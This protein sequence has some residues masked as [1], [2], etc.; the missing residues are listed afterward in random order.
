MTARSPAASR[1]RLP[2]ARANGVPAYAVTGND[3]LDPFE[4]RIVDLQVIL[5]AS[6]SRTLSAAGSKLAALV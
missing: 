4:A 1:S 6:T 2:R 5:Q 3:A